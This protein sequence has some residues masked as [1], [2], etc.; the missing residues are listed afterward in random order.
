MSGFKLP[1]KPKLKLREPPEPSKFCVIPSRAVGDKRISRATFR[2]L[3]AICMFANRGGFL[4]ASQTTIGKRCNLAQR[5]MSD[6]V[7]KL[8]ALGYLERVAGGVFGLRGDTNRVIFDERITEADALALME[9]ED[10]PPVIQHREMLS[11]ARKRKTELKVKLNENDSQVHQDS[12]VTKREPF[13]AYS[14]EMGER[15]LKSEADLLGDQLIASIDWA[16]HADTFS[17]FV[18]T[19]RPSSYTKS[20]RAYL[21]A[22]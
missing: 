4:W 3:A 21:Q 16:T 6:Y 2:A 5:T 20:V 1:K 8:R 11:M 17:A 7:R 9:S 10:K 13:E 12:L 19:L 18:R 14:L 15:R 22:L